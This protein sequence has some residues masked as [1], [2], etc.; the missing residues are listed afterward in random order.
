MSRRRLSQSTTRATLAAAL[1]GSAV[2]AT[3]CADEGPGAL[4]VPFTLGNSK[5]CDEVG[6]SRVRVVLGNEAYEEDADCGD[7][8]V[9]V[10]D[11]PAG[12]YD[13]L[14]EGLAADGVTI[15]DNLD[16]DDRRVE[17]VGDGAT[18]ELESVLLTDT[19]AQLLVR[20]DFGFSNCASADIA[21]FV[22]TAFETGGTSVLLEE[23][24]D[25]DSESDAPNGFHLVPD[26]DRSLKGGL[27]GE[28]NISAKPATTTDLSFMFEPPGP[29]RPI[30][31]SLECDDDGCEAAP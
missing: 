4:I 15:M 8:E 29:G 25:C 7:G 23:E 31:L 19:P 2:F 10:D 20:W 18:V 1:I 27:F 6:V 30:Y 12:R 21:Q 14:V 22:F 26:P 17:V 16:N 13:L 28:A 3:G 9:R 5:T 24:V 11:V